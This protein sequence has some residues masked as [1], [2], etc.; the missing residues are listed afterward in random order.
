MGDITLVSTSDAAAELQRKEKFEITLQ[1]DKGV[2]EKYSLKNIPA[3]TSQLVLESEKSILNNLSVHKI[4]KNLDHAADL[5]FLAYTALAA[6]RNDTLQGT[7]SGLQTSL[8]NSTVNASATMNTFKTQ[9]KVVVDEAVKAYTWLTKCKESMALTQLRRC[10]DAALEM[11]KK[12]E[13]LAKSFQTIVDGSQKAVETAINQKVADE[14]TKKKLKDKLNQ[15]TVL[16]TKTNTLQEKIQ[17]DLEDAQQ[18]YQQARD[19]EKV[20][21]ERAFITGIIGASIGALASGIG[22]VAQAAIA[23]KSP[24]GLPGGYVPPSQ[25]GSNQP[26]TQAPTA[27]SSTSAVQP[28]TESLSQQLQDKE[29]A[30]TA[31]DQ[32]KQD[33]EAKITAAEAIINDPDA[34]PQ[35]K[36]DANGKK[37]AAEAKRA[38]ID[39]RLQRAEDAVKTILNGLSGVSQQ[40]AQLSSQSHSAA[41]TASQQKILFYKHRNDLAKQNREA[42]ASLA[43]YAVLIKHTT[44]DTKNIETAIKSLQFA[45]E[46]LC[47]VVAALSETSLFWRNMANYCTETLGSPNFKEDLEL[48]ASSFSL[49]ERKDYYS[50]E[51]FLKDALV[52]IAQWVALNNVCEQYL[53]AVSEVRVKVNTN[54]GNP[55]SDD[56]AAAQVAGL[57]KAV[58]ESAKNQMVDIDAEM[59]SFELQIK[60]LTVQAQ[61]VS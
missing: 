52:N 37:T 16:Q 56:Q 30:K 23:I 58:L 15:I 14:N 44:Q 6:R 7:V 36:E 1:F 46:A 57:A 20:E 41:E 21:G 4:V 10:G 13:E 28:D 51:E 42:L 19:R 32:E 54:V 29:A 35:M 17:K 26:N 48:I 55:L 12:S 47:G 3:S 33:N 2:T 53:N 40:L 22:S 43:E 38:D 31:I 39:N 34:S 8:L 18:E 50:S 61:L 27:N 59:E 5:M 24:V 60:T 9:S 49:E 11:A 45:I 25:P